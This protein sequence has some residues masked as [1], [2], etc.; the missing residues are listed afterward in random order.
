LSAD[1]RGQAI[2]VE[3]GGGGPGPR[4][5]DDLTVTESTHQTVLDLN[6][7]LGYVEVYRGPMWDRVERVG[8]AKYL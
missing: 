6:A 4:R 1:A 3:M 7:Q 8:L 2:A 5:R